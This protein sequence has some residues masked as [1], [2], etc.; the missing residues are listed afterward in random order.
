MVDRHAAVRLTPCETSIMLEYS[1]DR[2]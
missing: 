2:N 1:S